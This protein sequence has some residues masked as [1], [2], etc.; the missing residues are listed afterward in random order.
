[1][2][3]K[4]EKIV[5]DFENQLLNLLINELTNHKPCEFIIEDIL[6]GF[7]RIPVQTRKNIGKKFAKCVDNGMVPNVKFLRT[8][9]SNKSWYEKY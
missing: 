4:I 2:Q 1:M 3:N 5:G 6:E 8:D 7:G 9:S